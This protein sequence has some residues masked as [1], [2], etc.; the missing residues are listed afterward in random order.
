MIKLSR[1]CHYLV[2]ALCGWLLLPSKSP[3]TEFLSLRLAAV[4]A[5]DYLEPLL[6][7]V[8]EAP[9]RTVTIQLV[10]NI[11]TTRLERMLATGEAS[12]MMLGET[13]ERNQRFLPIRVSMTDNLMNRRILLIPPGQQSVYDEVN[14]LEDL[15]ATGKVAGVGRSWRDYPIWRANNLPVNALDGDWK[16]LFRM[17]GAPGRGI[18]YL[19]RGALEVVEEW[20]KYPHL[21]VERRLVLQYEGDHILY[22]SPQMPELHTLLSEALPR[23]EREGLI[24]TRARAHYAGV[25][26]PPIT[27]QHRTTLTLEPETTTGQ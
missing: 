8:L 1:T 25:F 2:L 14:S 11:P 9:Q 4:N 26:L 6:M 12:A 15:R 19:S 18:D 10:D 7:D 17:V 21:V 22:V 23:A 3:A 5:A 27:L 20:Q 13:P 16:R 24:R